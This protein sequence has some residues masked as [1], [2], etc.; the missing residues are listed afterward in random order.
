MGEEQGWRGTA[1]R[2]AIAAGLVA[3]ILAAVLLSSWLSSRGQTDSSYGAGRELTANQPQPAS[4]SPSPPPR[5]GR[6]R[7]PLI[8][9]L[10]PTT[11]PAP[12]QAVG[13]GGARIVPL[14]SG[15]HVS[16]MHVDYY[17]AAGAFHIY[18]LACNDQDC[19]RVIEGA[20][21]TGTLTVTAYGQD[22][23]NQVLYSGQY[24]GCTARNADGAYPAG[25]Y[26]AVATHADRRRA[27]DEVY[28]QLTGSWQYQDASGS[29]NGAGEIPAGG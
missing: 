3:V 12:S 14:A 7:S 2:A 28:F 29:I 9:P 20:C 10:A 11:R 16:A 15:E 22:R 8:R 19:G 4:P 23:A 24:S 17:L 18:A 27:G 26:L 25:T 6:P 1:A 21:G 5:P 13:A